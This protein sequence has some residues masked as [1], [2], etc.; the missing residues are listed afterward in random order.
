[1][2][3]GEVQENTSVWCSKHS[4]TEYEHISVHNNHNRNH[5]TVDHAS[6]ARAILCFLGLRPRVTFL[7][8]VCRCFRFMQTVVRAQLSKVTV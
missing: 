3:L 7:C 6:T 1:M 2:A 8:Y 4:A 5:K